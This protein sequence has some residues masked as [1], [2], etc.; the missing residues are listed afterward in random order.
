M[1]RLAVITAQAADENNTHPTRD[2]ETSSALEPLFPTLQLIQYIYERSKSF[3][4]SVSIG[5]QR[6]RSAVRLRPL[7]FRSPTGSSEEASSFGNDARR[8]KKHKHRPASLANVWMSNQRKLATIAEVS[9]SDDSPSPGKQA[10]RS[11]AVDKRKVRSPL[12]TRFNVG[13]ARFGSLSM[14]MN[15][16]LLLAIEEGSA[17]L[18][19]V[20]KSPISP[21]Y[22]RA[23]LRGSVHSRKYTGGASSPTAKSPRAKVSFRSYAHNSDTR[24]LLSPGRGFEEHRLAKAHAKDITKSLSPRLAKS[25][26]IDEKK[27]EYGK[28][29][30]EGFASDKEVEEYTSLLG[31]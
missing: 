24:D 16:P 21:T 27:G 7:A 6:N 29:E 26:T 15:S 25:W 2:I 23:G 22:T 3:T 5:R 20:V 31:A 12:A 30:D 13:S 11:P 19:N 18:S 8:I 10:V 9:T 14:A 4:S 1:Y 17:G 28:R